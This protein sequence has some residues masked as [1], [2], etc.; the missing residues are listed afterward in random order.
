MNIFFPTTGTCE[1]RMQKYDMMVNCLHMCTR[2]Y[3]IFALISVAK[4]LQNPV[5]SILHELQGWT[6][7]KLP[8]CLQNNMQCS[9][10]S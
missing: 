9:L 6:F 2:F 4:I 7:D 10:N 8:H 3:R 1:E 5:S